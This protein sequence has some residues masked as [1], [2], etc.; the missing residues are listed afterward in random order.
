M[1]IHTW[2]ESQRPREKLLTRGADKLSDAELLAL[3]LGSGLPGCNA[4]ETARRALQ[5]AG[6]LRALM[7]MPGSEQRCLPGI[8]MAR[9]ALLAA[10]LELGRRFLGEALTRGDALKRPVDAAHYLC[11]CL[12]GHRHEVFACLFL[13]NKH[14]MLAFE[15]IFQGT[16]DSAAVYPREVLRRA[17]AHN[18]AAV[19]LAHNHPSGVA[20][21][22]EADRHI[23]AKL[24]R[25][26]DLVDVRVLDHLIIGDGVWTSLRERDWPVD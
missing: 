1:S 8:G 12:R 16:I 9:Q 11:A 26:L 15:E 19:I 13:D 14:R 5:Q 6:G 17:M 2:P 20:E 10:S 21:P 18:A 4:V 7:E 22:S 3:F 24:I 23:T 25:T